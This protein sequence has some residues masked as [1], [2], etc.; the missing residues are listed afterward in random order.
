MANDRMYLRCKG[1]KKAMMLAKH[2]LTPWFAESYATGWQLDD[3]MNVFFKEHYM[4]GTDANECNF[5]IVFE[6]GN[7]EYIP[8]HHNDLKALGE[9]FAEASLRER[10]TYQRIQ[11]KRKELYESYN[12]KTKLPTFSEMMRQAEDDRAEEIKRD[13]ERLLK[14]QQE[15]LDGINEDIICKTQ[16]EPVEKKD[17]VFE[18]MQD[19]FYKTKDNEDVDE[20]EDDRRTPGA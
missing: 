14:R 5:D 7:E 13:N 8:V 2:F 18:D 20:N 10:E 19:S 9:K 17:S 6:T 4:C 3:L 15:L 11:E 16:T 1:C 12:T